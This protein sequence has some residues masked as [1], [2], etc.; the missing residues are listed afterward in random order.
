MNEFLLVC[1]VALAMLG[2][3][4]LLGLLLAKGVE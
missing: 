3:F 1:G 2:C 4:A